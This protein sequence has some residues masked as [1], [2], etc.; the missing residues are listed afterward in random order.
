MNGRCSVVYHG[1]K[2]HLIRFRP[3]LH[4]DRIGRLS[5]L[6]IL[7]FRLARHLGAAAENWGLACDPANGHSQSDRPGL[8]CSGNFGLETIARGRGIKLALEDAVERRFGFVTDLTSNLR[9]TAAGG[10][11]ELRPQLQPPTCQVGP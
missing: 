3:G 9:D 6:D 4:F 5:T 10:R 2:A 8:F 1:G 11:E 7:S